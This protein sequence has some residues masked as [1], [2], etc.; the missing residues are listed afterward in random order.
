[1]N[2]YAIS[3]LHLSG[4][5]PKPMNIFGDNWDDHWDKIME[6]WREKVEPEDVVLIPG[7]IS[8]A[9]RMEEAKIDTDEICEMPGKKI[10]LRGNHDYWWSSISRVRAILYNETYV[11]QNDSLNFGDVWFAG[12]RGWVCPNEKEFLPDDEKIYLREV[13]RLKISLESMKRTDDDC[14]VVMMHYP[15]FNEMK[16][17]NGFT[18]LLETF[19]IKTVIYGHLHD[20]AA[21]RSFNGELNGITYHNVSC[22][23]LDFKLKRIL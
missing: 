18:E 23:Y 21:M 16:E 8:W 20:I 17:P 4:A 2:V 6:D 22:D 12:T 1:M 13:G 10:M 5:Q 7:D 19:G 9:M 3:D 11:I 15:P 14:V